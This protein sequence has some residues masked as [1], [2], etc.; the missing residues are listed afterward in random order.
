D[1]NNGARIP[2]SQEA[3]VVPLQMCGVQV[4]P[5]LHHW[6]LHFRAQAHF[7][8]CIFSNTVL[9]SLWLHKKLWK[10]RVHH[11]WEYV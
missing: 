5:R 2:P 8:C 10:S 6:P 7:Y 11:P 9:P 4:I 1:S 3:L